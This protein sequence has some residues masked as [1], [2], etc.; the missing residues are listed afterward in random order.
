MDGASTRLVTYGTLSPGQPN[1]HHLAG[2]PGRW[3]AGTVRGRLVEQGWGMELFGFPGLVLDPDGPH[4]PVHLLESSDLPCHWERL[5]AFEG[6]GYRRVEVPVSTAEG[7]LFGFI[8]V[9]APE[10]AGAASP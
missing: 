6:P 10:A 2:L 4:V 9:V 7:E 8:Y 3:L 1:H 5:D